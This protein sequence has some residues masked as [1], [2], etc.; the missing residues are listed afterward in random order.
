MNVKVP[1]NF[2]IRVLLFALFIPSALS[3]TLAKVSIAQTPPPPPSPA[4]MSGTLAD[5]LLEAKKR[6]RR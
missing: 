2:K 5:R 3:L 4:P 1:R 6:A